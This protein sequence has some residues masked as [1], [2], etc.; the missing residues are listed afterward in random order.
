MPDSAIIERMSG[1]RVASRLRA[2][3]SRALQ[4]AEGRRQG[5]RHRRGADPARRRPRGD[6][7]RSGSRSTSGRPGRWS[8]TTSAGRRR[9]SP[10][11]RPI[12]ASAASAASRRSARGRSPRSPESATKETQPWKSQARYSS[13]PAA[14]PASAKARRGCSPSTAPRSSSPISRPTRA[15]RSPPRSAA[16]SCAA[17]SPRRPTARRS[18]PPRSALGKLVGLVNCAGIALGIKTVGKEGAHPLASFTKTINVNLIGSFNMIR[19]AA[20]AMSRNEPEPTGERGVLISTA[21]VAAYDGQRARPPT[22]PP[23]AASSA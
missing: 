21:S 7:A 18:S 13:S 4:S 15:R 3:L 11:R 20:E 14:R 9:A 2:H 8:S 22:R 16:A 17:T 10:A 19:L 23:R 5:R 6:G 1:R 12:D